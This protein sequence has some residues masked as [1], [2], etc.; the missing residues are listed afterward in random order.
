MT[1]VKPLRRGGFTAALVGCLAAAVAADEAPTTA[2]ALDDLAARGVPV[3]ADTLAPLP[4]QRLRFDAPQ[5]QADLAGLAG[6]ADWE[7]FTADSINAPVTV[8]IE[9][10]PAAGTRLAHRVH[11]AFTLRAPLERL[12]ADETLRRSLGAEADA[13]AK[14]AAVRLL[15]AEELQAAGI[16]PDPSGRERLVAVELPLLNRVRIRGVVRTVATEHPDG[17]EVAWGFDE[18]LRDHPR[19]RPTWTRIEENELGARVEGEPQPY[20][21]CG[22]VVAVRRLAAEGGLDLLVVESRMVLAEPEAWFHGG[23]LVRSKI[24]LTTQEGVRSLRRRLQAAR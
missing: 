7:R 17:V 8:T 13:G 4:E 21:G 18:R 16:P 23:N 24:P 9:P 22:G 2:D 10:F 12:K 6:A 1:R 19:W 14:D 11:T 15:T 20:G 3:A 5:A